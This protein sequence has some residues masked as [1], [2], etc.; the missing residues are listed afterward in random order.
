MPMQV[1]VNYVMGVKS[2]KCTIVSTAFYKTLTMIVAM[3]TP[4]A[5]ISLLSRHGR[6]GI[7]ES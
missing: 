2:D 1:P 6:E 4:S 7:T 5:T 3:A